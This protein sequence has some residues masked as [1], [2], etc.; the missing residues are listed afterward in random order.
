MII[1]AKIGAFLFIN[2]LIVFIISIIG[3]LMYKVEEKEF[4]IIEK[5]GS[6]SVLVILISLFMMSFWIFT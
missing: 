6:A 5:I 2:S 4:K 3:C 1:I